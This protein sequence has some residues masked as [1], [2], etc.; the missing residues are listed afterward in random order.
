MLEAIPGKVFIVGVVLLIMTIA[1]S[2]QYFIFIAFLQDASYSIPWVLGPLNIFV[3]LIFYNYYLASTTDPGKIPINWE[4]PLSIINQ[5]NPIEGITAPPRF[6]KACQC[7]KPP[8]FI[9]V[10]IVVD[11]Y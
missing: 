2:S 6:C 3:L 9:I 7:Y 11:V 5:T 1:Y 10:D 4:P 8:R